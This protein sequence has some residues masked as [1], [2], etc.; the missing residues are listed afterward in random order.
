MLKN[1]SRVR[2]Y[3]FAS[4]KWRAIL[5]SINHAFWKAIS[6]QFTSYST[7]AIRFRCSNKTETEQKKQ[8]AIRDMVY[9]LL[10][11]CFFCS[12]GIAVDL[13]TTILSVQF[14]IGD[15]LVHN[16]RRNVLQ[17]IHRLRWWSGLMQPIVGHRR[18]SATMQSSASFATSTAECVGWKSSQ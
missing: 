18:I 3:C 6:Q 8:I 14:E 7:H 15:L 5:V 10:A 13:A 16:C 9:L 11:F 2:I 4:H 1:V 12:A 17:T